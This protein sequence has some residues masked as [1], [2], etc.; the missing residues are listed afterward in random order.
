METAFSF[1]SIC[2]QMASFFVNE[3]TFN[4]TESMVFWQFA[5][6]AGYV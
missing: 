5:S 3:E 4:E 2:S 1:M 6:V